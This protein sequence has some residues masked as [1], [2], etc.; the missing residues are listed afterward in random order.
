MVNEQLVNARPVNEW[1]GGD[2]KR[3]IVERMKVVNVVVEE[4]FGAASSPF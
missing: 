1:P 2:S 4:K 3:V